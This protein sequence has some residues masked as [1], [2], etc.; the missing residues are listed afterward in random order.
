M[1]GLLTYRDGL[2]ATAAFG[3]G[4]SGSVEQEAAELTLQARSHLTPL[5]AA[6]DPG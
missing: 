3:A 4:P 1:S 2:D 5:T 6:N